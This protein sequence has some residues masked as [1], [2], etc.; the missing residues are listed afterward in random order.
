VRAGIQAQILLEGNFFDGVD[1]PHE[2]NNADDQ[3]TANITADASNTYLN[4]T[5]DRLTGG[6]GPAFTDAPYP[7]TLDDAAGIPEA[8]TLGAGPH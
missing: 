6:G 2:F 8:V 7:Y 1:D 5:S 3:L 4:T